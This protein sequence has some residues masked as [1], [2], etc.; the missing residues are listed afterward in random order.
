[1]N[2]LNEKNIFS[3]LYKYGVIESNKIKF[4]NFFFNFG[5]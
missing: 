1:M 3:E 4:N 5:C 2:I